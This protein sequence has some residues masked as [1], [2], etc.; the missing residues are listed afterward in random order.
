MTVRLRDDVDLERVE[1]DVL[2]VVDS[3]FHPAT[4]GLWLRGA[5][6]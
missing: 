4:A 1:A 3:T 6:R 2:G 5:P